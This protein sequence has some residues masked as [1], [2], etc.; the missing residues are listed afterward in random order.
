MS[1]TP[2]LGELRLMSFN[3]PPK[4]WAQCSGQLL[5]I[6]ANQALFALLGTMY[7]GDGR[8]NFA[9][10]DLRG[11][12]P[13]HRGDGL[14]QGQRVGQEFHALTQGEMPEHL[15]V[16]AASASNT[17]QPTPKILGSANNLYGEPTNLTTL[18]PQTI[19]SVGGGQPHENR[20]PALTL[21]WCIALVG[22]FPSQN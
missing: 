7:G 18:N 19:A 4:G 17:D 5:P 14:T 12:A 3:F 2:F 16:A 20:Q 6:N 1:D 15:H 21:E 10:P 8:V 22:I 11:R 13:V 9:L